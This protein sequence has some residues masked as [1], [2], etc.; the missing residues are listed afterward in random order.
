MFTRGAPVLALVAGATLLFAGAA[1]VTYR[2]RGWTW[3]S[4]GLAL[5]TLV[6]GVGGIVESLVDRVTLA[7]DAL[8]VRRLWGTT[9]YPVAEIERVEEAK[10][11]PPAVL[12]R[13]GRWVRLPDVGDHFGNSARAWLRAGAHSR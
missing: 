12:L 9:R 3:V 8:V 6:F 10:G 4:G 13:S 7:P 5:A 2:Q 1:F 11:A